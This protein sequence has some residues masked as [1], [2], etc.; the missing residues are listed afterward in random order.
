LDVVAAE[1][2]FEMRSRLRDYVQ[3]LNMFTLIYM[4]LSAVVPAMLMVVVMIAA[5]RGGGMTPEKMGIFYLL[6]L[7]F[8]LV[9]F[10]FMMKRAEPRL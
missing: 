3:K 4:F 10:V 5:G 7:P 6:L 8:L 9:Y 1:T 2:A